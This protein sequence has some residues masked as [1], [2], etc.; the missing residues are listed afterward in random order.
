MRSAIRSTLNASAL[1][2]GSRHTDA[3]RFACPLHCAWWCSRPSNPAIYNHVRWAA[4]VLETS[5][6][7]YSCWVG[8]CK[9]WVEIAGPATPQIY[10]AVP[11]EIR[12]MA[13]W[14]VDQCVD[15]NGRGYGGFATKDISQLTAY[16]TEPDTK[17]S[18]TYRKWAMYVVSA[19]KVPYWIWPQYHSSL[20]C[21]S[22]GHGHRPL[23]SV[24]PPAFPRK[25]WP[26]DCT[27]PCRRRNQRVEQSSPW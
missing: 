26:I 22:N 6:L 13:G 17:I 21:V 11:N 7:S 5:S 27:A 12:G 9:I 15:S 1:R 14:V 23:G 20:H 24:R 25:L 10:E 16:V 2:L 4:T 3:R 18:Q 8:N 19:S